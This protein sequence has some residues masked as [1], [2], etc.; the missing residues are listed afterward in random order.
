MKNLQL[1]KSQK[2]DLTEILFD[3]F[4]IS[5]GYRVLRPS[6]SDSHYD[7]VVEI[8]G[9]LIKFQIKGVFMDVSSKSYVEIKTRMKNGKPYDQSS[10]DY[11]AAYLY[12]VDSWYFQ[13]N[14]GKTVMCVSRKNLNNFNKCLGL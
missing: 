9:D 6:G 8:M 11:F 13:K 14:T 12:S 7:R 10:V 1:S 5:M 3:S 4:V 2:G